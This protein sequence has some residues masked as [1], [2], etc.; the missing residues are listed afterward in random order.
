MLCEETT[1]Q[2]RN[3]QLATILMVQL[4]NLMIPKLALEDGGTI[5]MKY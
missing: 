5:S 4:N 1:A 3:D 2:I